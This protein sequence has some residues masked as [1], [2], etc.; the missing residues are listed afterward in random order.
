MPT[1]LRVDPANPESREL[2]P[3][4]AAIKAGEVVAIPT[5]TLYG[6]AANPF[7]AAAVERVFAIKGRAVDQALPLLAA[8][9]EQIAR[10]L[11]P[12]SAS[13]EALASRFWPGPLTLLMAAPEGLVR[14]V[15]G[16]TGLVGVRVPAHPVA[17]ALC[18][19]SELP[20]TATSANRSGEPP[21]N[22]PDT[23][24]RVLGPGL[25][26]LIDAGKTAGG[27]PSTIVDATGAVPRLIRAGAIAWEDIE[28]CL[29][30]A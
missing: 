6:L 23:V 11:G 16:G 24:A 8:D 30:A 22:D 1:R 7:D 4:I 17:R 13:G 2:L 12:L 21:T 25:A 19:M 5:D 28:A 10:R 9:A 15:H 27:P 29:R 18:R 3:A 20:L 14:E 26:V